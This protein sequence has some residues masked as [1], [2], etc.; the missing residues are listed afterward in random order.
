MSVSVVTPSRCATADSTVASHLA[1]SRRS[2]D[3]NEALRG[4]D[5]GAHQ[6]RF[7]VRAVHV[8]ELDHGVADRVERVLIG[9]LVED[10]LPHR[11]AKPVAVAPEHVLFRGEVTEERTRGDPDLL[12]DLFD[13]DRVVAVFCEQLDRSGRQV[14]ARPLLLALAKCCGRTVLLPHD[15]TLEGVLQLLPQGIPNIM[16]VID[17][18]Y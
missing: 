2:R 17:N 14:V 11:G 5:L 7:G 18:C 3:R 4:D 6:D 13:G 9:G 10:R 12:G 15:I 1:C 8:G 16:T